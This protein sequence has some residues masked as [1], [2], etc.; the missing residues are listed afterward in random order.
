VG[1]LTLTAVFRQTGSG[2]GGGGWVGRAGWGPQAALSVRWVPRSVAAQRAT[3]HPPLLRFVPRQCW[4]PS[5]SPTWATPSGWRA[6]GR[7]C[8][9]GGRR[10]NGG[11]GGG[12]GVG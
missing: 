9:S 12:G 6:A 5:A 2:G 11:G 1:W 10:Q 7:C 3:S 4:P 8:W